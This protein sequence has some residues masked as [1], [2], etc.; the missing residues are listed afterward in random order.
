VGRRPGCHNGKRYFT[1]GTLL[2]LIARSRDSGE[3]IPV[4]RILQ[5]A[6]EIA[7]GLAYVH[8]RRILYLDLQPRNVLFDELETVHL[9]DFDTA[10]LSA[11]P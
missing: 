11:Y 2:D 1:G 9:V 6:T 5:V 7:H 3:N 10:V 8:G 4:E